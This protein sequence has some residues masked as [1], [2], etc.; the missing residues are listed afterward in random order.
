MSSLL[1]D[2][3]LEG[4]PRPIVEK[5]RAVI[6]RARMVALLRGLIAV[7]LVAL[8]ALLV[9]M[10]F[11]ATITIFSYWGRAALS[12]TLLGATLIAAVVF[13]IL[14]LRRTY[15]LAGIARIIEERHPELE[16]RLS[17]S[18]ELL[19]SR[20]A[21]E[22]RGSEVLIAELAKQAVGQVGEV[23]PQKE[24]S[25]TVVAR[26]AALLGAALLIFAVVF[27]IWPSTAALLVTRVVAPFANVG[28]VQAE[29]MQVKPG[30]IVI[31]RGDS[32][33]VEALVPHTRVRSARFFRTGA[34]GRE[35]SE[36]MRSLSADENGY[37]RFFLGVA[38]VEE[39][40]RYRLNS[41]GALTQYYDVTVTPRPEVES[42]RIEYRY[43]EYA[44]IPPRTTDAATGDIEALVGTEV[45]LTAKLN[46]AIKSA[47]LTVTGR[48][49]LPGTIAEGSEGV[50]VVTWKIALT[51]EYLLGDVYTLQLRDEHSFANLPVDY[52][53]RSLADQAPKIAISEPAEEA[54]RMKPYDTLPLA[55]R[56][57]DDYG[58]GR[59]DMIAAIDGEEFAPRAIAV[60]TQASE[61][62]VE[63]TSRLR[64]SEIVEPGDRIVTVE[65]RVV[66]NLP[67][68]KGPQ[69]SVSRRITITLD[70][71]AETYF[72]K[73]IAADYASIRDALQRA[74]EDLKSADQRTTGLDQVA[75][76]DGSLP[77]P[78]L[79]RIDEARERVASAETTLLDLSG[80]MLETAYAALEYEVANLAET[81]VRMAGE[82]AGLVKLS[83]MAAE[84]TDRARESDAHVD[85]AIERTEALLAALDQAYENLKEIAEIEELAAQEAALAEDIAAAPLDQPLPQPLAEMQED[86][87]A[88][89]AEAVKEL[90]L[91]A[92]Q[93]LQE[94]K[95]E[96][97]DLAAAAERLAEAQETLQ[98]LTEMA[99][100]KE[101]KLDELVAKMKEALLAEQQQI[102]VDAGA[103][104]EDVE[105]ANLAG[106]D[107]ASD[108]GEEAAGVA[109][110]LNQDDIPA[111]A[112]AAAAAAERFAEAASA[113]A[114]NKPVPDAPA[115]GEKAA[116]EDPAGGDQ[117]AGMDPAGADGGMP[118]PGD[119][120]E[121]GAPEGAMPEAGAPEGGKPEAGKPEAGKPEAGAPEAGMPEAGMPEGGM[122]EG[123]MPEGGEP[124]AGAPEGGVPE[125]GDAE[126]VGMPEAAGDEGM[127]A[128]GEAFELAQEASGLA[129]RQ[130]SVAE[131]L[132]ALAEGK[133]D[134]ALAQGQADVAAESERLQMTAQ[135][136]E[137]A[138]NLLG[139]PNGALQAAGKAAE[140]LAQAADESGQAAENLGEIAPPDAGAGEEGMLAGAEPPAGA[141]GSTPA[142]G[143]PENADAAEGMPA[144]QGAPAA[145][146]QVAAGED[147]APA[148]AEGA[149][150]AMGEPQVAGTD[151]AQALRGEAIGA[152]GQAAESFK[153]AA[154]AFKQLGEQIQIPD[155]P[156]PSDSL[157]S[158]P[159]SEAMAAGLSE[160]LGSAAEAMAALEA[161]EAGAQANASPA[162]AASAAA[163]QAAAA[164][165]AQRTADALAAAAA[166]AAAAGR[167]APSQ[168]ASSQRGLPQRGRSPAQGPPTPSSQAAPGTG[169]LGILGGTTD[170]ELKEKL[171]EYGISVADW[172]RLPGELK[173]RIRQAEAED[174]PEEYR[175]MVRS[176]FREIARR[177]GR[178][179]GAK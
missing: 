46:K 11:D 128:F 52:R 96:A 117:P 133:L 70:E 136:V 161:A 34:D 80:T 91:A 157:A 103:F 9:G 98:D 10:A 47:G 40:F 134:Q 144:G 120:P 135:A 79:V 139:Q 123:G 107:D 143:A 58:I 75:N 179:P 162:D 61:R 8:V 166:Q 137:E 118:E 29:D 97:E 7:A 57:E 28:N 39:S 173:N 93:A 124:E 45:T 4:V 110:A 146:D 154:E 163:A 5:L 65:L 121:A 172:T 130:R 25:L 87:A 109:E 99:N 108:L 104:D 69:E 64:L 125:A 31:A 160:A 132:E 81:D 72:E 164:A 3:R 111:A 145:A 149:A 12:F 30:D 86:L 23:S 127:P 92:I 158:V 19:S 16:E 43:P 14:P 55:Y 101:P 53:I 6:R 1:L 82:T 175:E 176:Y 89:I 94:Q 22:L 105:E 59:V 33:H 32:L 102:A 18:V 151:E 24:F 138:L 171:D 36:S 67:Q 44:S 42:F 27:A 71:A 78:T 122:P 155:A 126:G 66:D 119:A 77:E 174:A 76:V 131:R 41:G 153:A 156:A 140:E 159:G 177:S 56:A 2:P 15:S 20:D 74:L 106:E 148:G 35:T 100:A 26:F 54:L 168:T 141:E 60:S 147:Q 21:W 169:E 17:S 38:A 13:L 84:R 113:L 115:Q 49:S 114:M 63:G 88:H 167:P 85:K 83:D 37:P 62:V 152:Q 48:E 90:P 150:P 50:S 51:D 142:A 95:E 170:G 116:G 165:A 112:E 178:A 129:A 73:Q 68:P